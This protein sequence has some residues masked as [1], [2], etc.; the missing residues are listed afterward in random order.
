M[1]KNRHAEKTEQ[2]TCRERKKKQK[3]N[4]AA[5]KPLIYYFLTTSRVVFLAE[6]WNKLGNEMYYVNHSLNLPQ[7]FPV[8]LE[9]Q[10]HRKEFALSKQ[11]PLFWHG[12]LLHF[13]KT[14][15][16]DGKISSRTF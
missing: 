9:V 4:I 11:V 12:L 14:T 13:R 16:I 10:T 3:K 1:Q 7:N 2:Q 15:Q 6:H 8:Q 5:N